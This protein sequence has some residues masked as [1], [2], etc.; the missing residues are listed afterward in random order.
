MEPKDTVLDYLSSQSRNKIIFHS[1]LH[2]G[3]ETVN[4]GLRLSE[5][6]Y[7][8]SD[9]STIAM[10]AS[11]KLTEI[12]NSAI[13]VHETFGRCLSIE[14]LGILFEPELKVDFAR[15]LDNYSQ[16]NVLFVKWDGELDGHNICFLT[17]EN[18]V[19][20]TITNLS[21]IAL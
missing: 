1:G 10:Q 5:A 19:K 8:F 9:S 14:N 13:M 3:V 15:L 21:H 18:G 2:F 12:L 20:I 16:N 17:K 6:I 11:T 4:V 7:N